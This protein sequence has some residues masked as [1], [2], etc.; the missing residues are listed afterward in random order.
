MELFSVSTLLDTSPTPECP[1]WAGKQPKFTQAST[2]PAELG[3]HNTCT[4]Q[5]RLPKMFDQVIQPFLGVG[6]GC[7][8]P[9]K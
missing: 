5:T 4:S 2:H 9:K 6:W 7:V 8:D 3:S 1:T